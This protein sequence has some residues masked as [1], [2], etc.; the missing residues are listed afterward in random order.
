MEGSG[1]AGRPETWSGSVAHQFK[2]DQEHTNIEL[3]IPR[4]IYCRWIYNLWPCIWSTG[5]RVTF[6]SSDFS[7]LRVQLPLNLRTYNRVG[8]IFGG[9]MYSA[10][11]PFYMI[12]LMEILGREYV[13]WDKGAS[14]R[15]KRPGK[16]VLNY[17]FKITDETLA[18]IRAKVASDREYT[19]DLLVNAVDSAGSVHAE[20]V[21]T[22]YVASKAHYKEKLKARTMKSIS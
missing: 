22:M 17:H 11:D 18:E 13:V 3:M 19:F 9:S 1:H 5:A 4:H 12:M 15:F 2:M 20:I 21:K 6:I 16:S 8:T 7:E 10:S 14:I